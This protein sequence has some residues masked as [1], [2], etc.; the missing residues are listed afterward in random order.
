MHWPDAKTSCPLGNGR[1]KHIGWAKFELYRW[2]CW[3]VHLW[4]E[5]QYHNGILRKWG[6][7]LIFVEKVKGFTIRAPWKYNMEVFHLNVFRSSLSPLEEDSSSRLESSEHFPNKG[8]WIENWRPWS[9]KKIKWWRWCHLAK[10]I[11]WIPS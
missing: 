2:L 6:F 3:L 4:S 5:S 7:R 11:W 1:N 8:Q 9:S 10:S